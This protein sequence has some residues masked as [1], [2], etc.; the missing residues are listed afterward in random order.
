MHIEYDDFGAYVE[1]EDNGMLYA[2][3]AV[4]DV[5]EQGLWLRRI[6][7]WKFK[8]VRENSHEEGFLE[9]GFYD[10]RKSLFHKSDMQFWA[11]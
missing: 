9:F 3:G 5:G 4:E 8:Y 2:V 1:V 11:V 6:K 10:R 7:T